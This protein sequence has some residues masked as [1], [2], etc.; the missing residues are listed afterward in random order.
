MDDWAARWANRLLGN[1]ADAALLE[2]TGGGLVLEAE[3]ASTWALAGADLT[4]T[5]DG[6]PW[7]PGHSRR[8]PAGAQVV[9]RGARGP[10]LRA[11]LAVPGGVEVPPVLGSRS[12][13]L[14]AGLGGLEGRVLRAGDRLRF[15]DTAPEPKSAPRA[16]AD[17]S[18]RLRLLP[19]T[20]LDA[21]PAEAAAWLTTRPWQVSPELSRSGLRLMGPPLALGAVSGQMLSQGMALGSVQVPPGGQPLVLLKDR[22]T[23]GGYPVVAHVI[24]ADWPRLAQLTP[25][26]WVSC[27][28]IGMA[29]AE[30]AWTQQQEDW[31][32]PLLDAGSAIP[33]PVQYVTAPAA[34]VVQELVPEGAWVAAGEPMAVLDTMGIRSEVPAPIAGRAVYIHAGRGQAVKAGQLLGEVHE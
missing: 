31:A 9:L 25:G 11:Y 14:L 29:A 24:R 17:L 2:V 21:L 3:A 30:Q 12:T 32:L 7:A 13:D 4:A 34:G 6:Q 8:I 18:R 15:S 10:G 16:T 28:W 20:G 27:R 19:G 5:V 26:D 23:I 22:G 33:S 1:P